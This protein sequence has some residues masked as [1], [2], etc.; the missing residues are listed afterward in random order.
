MAAAGGGDLAAQP[1][2]LIAGP[3]PLFQQYLRA[4]EAL[5]HA[6][7]TWD[8]RKE[9]PSGTALQ[10]LVDDALSNAVR[11]IKAR[12]PSSLRDMVELAQVAANEM[13]TDWASDPGS[14]Y[15]FEEALARGLLALADGGAHG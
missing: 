1:F 7:T 8:V 2:S 10:A 14:T 5:L 4:R 12:R 6:Y 15:D 3:S 9:T 13:A 11:A